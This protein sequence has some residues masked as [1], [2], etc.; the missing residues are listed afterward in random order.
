MKLEKKSDCQKGKPNAGTFE[1]QTEYIA[2]GR[3]L[4]V[5]IRELCPDDMTISSLEA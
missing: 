1:L 2:S 3:L 4:L 5:V